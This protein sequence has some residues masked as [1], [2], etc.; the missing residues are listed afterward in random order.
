MRILI[1]A[2]VLASAA[3]SAQSIRPGSSGVNATSVANA[4]AVMKSGGGTTATMT[5]TLTMSGTTIDA[6]TSGNEDYTIDPGGGSGSGSVVIISEDDLTLFNDSAGGSDLEVLTSTAGA[7]ARLRA[8][9][10]TG[11]AIGMDEGSTRA[12][13][14][15][16]RAAGHA[17]PVFIVADGITSPTAGN[18]LLSVRGA[19]EME[20]VQVTTGTVPYWR[21]PAVRANAAGALD[22]C[23]AASDEFR[24]TAVN[25]TNDTARSRICV[26]LQGSDDSTFAWR[27][28]ADGTTACAAPSSM[29]T[30]GMIAM[31]TK[32]A[33]VLTALIFSRRVFFFYLHLFRRAFRRLS[34]C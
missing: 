8:V 32:H 15:D 23:A 17:T 27:D 34:S 25:D 18:A 4:G 22:T 11:G 21:L 2:L 14:L 5:Q 16:D 10:N 30:L 6:T 3:G 1:L 24:V 28:I 29:S 9:S 12:G 20:S 26:C 19:G 13:T 33:A 31:G 7:R